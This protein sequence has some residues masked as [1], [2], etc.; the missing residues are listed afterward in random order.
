MS[1]GRNADHNIAR[2]VRWYWQG[3]REV[4]ISYL[5]S[6]HVAGTKARV[7]YCWGGECGSGGPEQQ[8]GPAAA[9]GG[10]LLAEPAPYRGIIH[11]PQAPCLIISAGSDPW[12]Y[13]ER[14]TCMSSSMW[15]SACRLEESPELWQASMAIWLLNHRFKI[16]FAIKICSQ[17][18]A[19]S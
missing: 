10:L 12:L 2:T 16:K 18:A 19:S 13:Q 6:R 17:N 7:G 5:I 1:R 4:S 14:L 8:C 3:K 11:P 15:A 9:A